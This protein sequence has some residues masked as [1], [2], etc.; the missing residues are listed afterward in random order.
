MFVTLCGVI[1][2]FY[3]KLNE[4]SLVQSGHVISAATYMLL[5]FNEL[6][7]AASIY[8]ILEPLMTLESIECLAMPKI[9]SGHFRLL[10]T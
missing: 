1:C 10:I 5:K 6:I 2:I 7:M 3:I 8:W 4:K 9:Y